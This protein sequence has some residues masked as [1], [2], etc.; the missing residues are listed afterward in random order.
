MYR[1]ILVAYYFFFQILKTP[2][3]KRPSVH[4][5]HLSTIFLGQI[6][7]RVLFLHFN[8]PYEVKT[9]IS[10]SCLKRV[11][12]KGEES[13][14]N[15]GLFILHLYLGSGAKQI[16]RFGKIAFSLFFSTVIVMK[17]IIIIEFNTFH[18]VG[19]LVLSKRPE[20]LAQVS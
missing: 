18:Y 4:D 6:C 20:T 17:K 19:I 11:F 12:I 2:R 3:N 1:S 14:K 9:L 16:Q 10:I 8:L 13:R 7:C 5:G 15:L